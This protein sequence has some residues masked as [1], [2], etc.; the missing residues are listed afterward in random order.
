MKSKFDPRGF[1]YKLH[2]FKVSKFFVSGFLYL[3]AV[4]IIYDEYQYKTN[5]KWNR[6][7]HLT[8]ED[9]VTWNKKSKYEDCV[10]D[11]EVQRIMEKLKNGQEK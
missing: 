3:V 8:R 4:R 5:E 7:S 10:I 6:K 2:L 9:M 1:T 11:S